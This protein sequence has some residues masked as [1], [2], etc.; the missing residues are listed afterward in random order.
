MA[1]NNLVKI[2]VHNGLKHYMLAP[3]PRGKGAK[4]R[5]ELGLTVRLPMLRPCLLYS[6]QLV[7]AHWLSNF[8]HPSYPPCS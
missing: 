1:N 5:A 3:L 2:A 7:H 6:A 4:K 8:Q